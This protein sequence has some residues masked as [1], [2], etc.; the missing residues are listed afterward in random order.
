MA[1]PVT[2][3]LNLQEV[4][5]LDDLVD[6]LRKRNPDWSPTRSDALRHLIAASVSTPDLIA[7]AAAA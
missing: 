4:D 2:V 5:H 7:G 6:R 3:R 1:N